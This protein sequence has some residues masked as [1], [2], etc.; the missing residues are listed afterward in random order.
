MTTHPT[1][2]AE[3][4][5]EAR[6]DKSTSPVCQLSQLISFYTGYQLKPAQKAPQGRIALIQKHDI[7]SGILAT[8]LECANL[9]RLPAEQSL[10]PG[11]I[12][13]HPPGA[14]ATRVALVLL[15]AP[16]P[17]T[18][19]VT[20]VVRIRVRNP[21]ALV[22]GYLF[23]FLRTSIGQKM[24][25]RYAGE[26]PPVDALRESLHALTLPMPNMPVQQQIADYYAAACASDAKAAQLR[27]ALA[28]NREQI[29][30]GLAQQNGGVV[31]ALDCS[32]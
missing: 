32:V 29:L 21:Q 6:L 30:L 11:D 14:Q 4:A 1:T 31:P 28:C 16:T 15:D 7:A 2:P 27:Q 26:G 13:L 12:L 25:M 22:P 20:P 17:A 3:G 10:Q 9:P 5:D 18:L 19:C 23:W 8:K 24:L